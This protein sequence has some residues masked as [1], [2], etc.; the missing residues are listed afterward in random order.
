MLLAVHSVA[1]VVT[2]FG[3]SEVGYCGNLYKTWSLC[4]F[5]LKSSNDKIM[6]N[7]KFSRANPLFI[8]GF[9]RDS[10]CLFHMLV[11]RRSLIVDGSGNFLD[12]SSIF[13]HYCD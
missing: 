8:A 13:S 2:L 11:D 12:A 4:I 1:V 6:H 5:Q 10:Y 7:D 9:L 3:L